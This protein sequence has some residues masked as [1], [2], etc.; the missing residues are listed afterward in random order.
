MTSRASPSQSSAMRTSRRTLPL[1]SPFRQ[2][3]SRDREWKWTIAGRERGGQGLGIHPGHHQ[4]TPV[5]DVLHDGR[6]EPVGA[7]RDLGAAV[8]T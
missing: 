2:S 7:E 4:D 5:G 8:A 1:V 6:D 3:R